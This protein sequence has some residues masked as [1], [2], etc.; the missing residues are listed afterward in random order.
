VYEKVYE[1][2]T[3][4][5]GKTITPEVR[6]KLLGT[7]ERQSCETCVNDLGLNVS[8]EDFLRDFQEISQQRLGEVDLMPGAERLIRHLHANKISICVA[9]SSG[10]ESVKVKTSKHTE[11]F[12]F[13]HHITCGNDPEIKNGKPA[14]DIFLLAA[15]R[16]EPK[17]D[18][19]KVNQIKFTDQTLN[20][21]CLFL[22][23]LVI[24]DSPNGVQAGISAGMQV[25][26]VPTDSVSSE[27]KAKATIAIKSLED[28]T[29][30]LFGLP[31]F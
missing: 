19:T 29:P 6:M 17:A 4:K 5:Y 26:M 7:P 1:E 22:Q 15:S 14:P 25:V 16:F 30:E 13:F 3:S 27:L 21:L 10:N 23:C 24:E 2:V 20:K 28:F 18:P 8:L 12:K 9:T 31:P 11:L